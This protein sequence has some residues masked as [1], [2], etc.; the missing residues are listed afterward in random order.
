MRRA[1][2]NLMWQPQGLIASN[3]RVWIL[4][5]GKISTASHTDTRQTFSR[6]HCNTRYRV[7]PVQHPSITRLSSNYHPGIIESVVVVVESVWW[8]RLRARETA[9]SSSHRAHRHRHRHT[10]P[11]S[12]SHAPLIFLLEPLLKLLKPWSHV[13]MGQQARQRRRC[14]GAERGH[15][16]PGAAPAPGVGDHRSR[17]GSLLHA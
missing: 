1:D 11:S 2:K 4:E 10:K 3:K 14:L 7:P 9:R 12:T 6:Y 8:I 5:K 13:G 16:S 15:R 17:Q